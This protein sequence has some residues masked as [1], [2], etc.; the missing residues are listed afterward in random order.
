MLQWCLNRTVSDLLYFSLHS[1][2]SGT[3]V[4]GENWYRCEC[5]PGFAGPDCRISE[6]WIT[7]DPLDCEPCKCATHLFK[8][9]QSWSKMQGLATQLANPLGRM[10]TAQRTA[11][12]HSAAL[13]FTTPREKLTRSDRKPISL[14]MQHWLQSSICSLKSFHLVARDITQALLFYASKPANELMMWMSTEPKMIE[15]IMTGC[16]GILYELASIKIL[17]FGIF[18]SISKVAW[19]LSLVLSKKLNSR[20]SWKT[21]LKHLKQSCL[22]GKYIYFLTIFQCFYWETRPYLLLFMR[23]ESFRTLKVQSMIPNRFS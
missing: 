12:L 3:C 22:L 1:Y 14:V 19:Q 7:P 16:S 8:N 10:P 15:S 18:N 17:S 21:S 23:L 6:C 5:A 11:S 4:D 9:K 2:N 20:Y 13:M